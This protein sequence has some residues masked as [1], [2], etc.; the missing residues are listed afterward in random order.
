M[1]GTKNTTKIINPTPLIN[2]ASSSRLPV[3]AFLKKLCSGIAHI[4]SKTMSTTKLMF[5]QKS[6]LFSCGVI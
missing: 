5:A 3:F 2:G 6:A 4:M 1:P